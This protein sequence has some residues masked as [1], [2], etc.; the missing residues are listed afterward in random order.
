MAHTP[1][2]VQQRALLRAGT[3]WLLLAL[4]LT[5]ALAGWAS[6]FTVDDAFITARYAQRIVALGSYSFSDGAASDGV[7]GPLWLAPLL[8]GALLQ[9]DLLRI[10]KLV[11][12]AC[13]LLS[14]LLV[15][16]RAKGRQLGQRS[17]LFALALIGSSVP[18]LIWSVAGLETGAAC[19]ATTTLLLGSAGTRFAPMGV[20]L[21][22]AALVWLRPELAVIVGFALG[23]ALL[24]TGREARRSVL[25]VS[26]GV[27]LLLAFRMLHFGHMLPLSAHAKP[28]VL[29]HGLRYL[30][31][32]LLTPSALVLLPPLTC[33]LWWGR[34][35]ERTLGLALAGHALAVALAGGDWM[36]SARLFVPVV[37]VACYLAAR[38]LA[39]LQLRSAWG[40]P[41]VLALLCALRGFTLSQELPRARAAG[42]LR[43]RRVPELLQALAPYPD[44]IVILDIGAVGYYGDRD[45]IDLGG[46]T[47]P[48]IAYSPGGH[49]SKRIDSSW[50]AQRKPGAIVLHSAERP[51]VDAQRRLRWFAGYPVER[52]VLA[53]TWVLQQYR[54]A[55]VLQYDQ[56][57]FYVVLAPD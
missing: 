19:L 45:V 5:A 54:V 57:Y 44:P 30:A 14:M 4:A 46:L 1:D 55:R 26:M 42:R 17:A 50:L 35:E 56:R 2:S 41:L 36:A 24:R 33:A 23:V 31:D 3:G 32:C 40:A 13:A 6:P 37:P 48:T 29:E 8:A 38:G 21:A 25:L 20:G 52:N 18:L 28:P 39:Y 22:G 51:R 9:I 15:W 34:R 7:T 10:A 47:D 16:R 49:L 53:M 43:E 27:A 11:G 12:L